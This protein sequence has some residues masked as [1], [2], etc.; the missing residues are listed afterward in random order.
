[1]S[2]LKFQGDRFPSKIRANTGH[3]DLL[4]LNDDALSALM[5]R[6]DLNNMPDYCLHGT[7]RHCLN[8]ILREGLIPGGGRKAR[9]WNYFSPYRYGDWRTTAGARAHDEVSI[10]FDIKAMVLAGLEMY[11]T[12]CDSLIIN[13]E[14]AKEYVYLCVDNATSLVLG[15]RQDCDL[16]DCEVQGTKFVKATGVTA[17]SGVESN[18]RPDMPKPSTFYL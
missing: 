3:S 16:P 4:N 17:R 1:M 15:A 7:S 5:I 14:V 2:L 11:Y 9:K 13:S 10:Y 8:S 12:D 6:V 18:L